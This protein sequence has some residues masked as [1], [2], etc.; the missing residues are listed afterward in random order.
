MTDDQLLSQLLQKALPSVDAPRPP[1]DL[2][3]VVVQRAAAHEKVSAADLGVAA[4]IATML[5][6]FPQW[7]WFLA[8]HL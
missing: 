6:M 7:F 8:Y 5:L 2:W 3:P 1:A 4:I